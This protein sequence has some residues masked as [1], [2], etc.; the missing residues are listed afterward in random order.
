MS[1]ISLGILRH[2]NIF[3]ALNRE[4]DYVDIFQIN[5]NSNS[6]DGMMVTT[7]GCL[8]ISKVCENDYV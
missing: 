6:I 3:S 8:H 1:A 2:I 7:N 4:D 5:R